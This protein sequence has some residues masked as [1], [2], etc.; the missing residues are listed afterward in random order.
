MLSF[1]KFAS[2]NILNHWDVS[3]LYTELKLLKKKKKRGLGLLSGNNP[4]NNNQSVFSKW[5]TNAY[6]SINKCTIHEIVHCIIFFILVRTNH[7]TS[8]ATLLSFCSHTRLAAFFQREREREKKKGNIFG[9]F[10]LTSARGKKFKLISS[11]RLT[12]RHFLSSALRVTVAVNWTLKS[13]K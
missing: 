3:Y 6:I 11:C 7:G 1:M 5:C 9:V 10:H 2:D 12:R 13:K 4:K 8:F